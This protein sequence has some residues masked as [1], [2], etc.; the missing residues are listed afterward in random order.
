MPG[1]TA[2]DEEVGQDV[3]D[4][5]GLELPVDPDRDAFPGKLVDDIGANVQRL[6]L[7]IRNFRPLWVR[8]STK[9]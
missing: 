2:Q 6:S 5:R 4:V 1:H 8:S 3:N 7:D 9:S